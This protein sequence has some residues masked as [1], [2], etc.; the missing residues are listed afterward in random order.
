MADRPCQRGWRSYRW[1]SSIVD[2][3]K[4]VQGIGAVSDPACIRV[5]RS[6]G[7]GPR[8]ADAPHGRGSWQSRKG[9]VVTRWVGIDLRWLFRR[10]LERNRSFGFGIN[11]R[12]FDDAAERVETGGRVQR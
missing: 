2:R 12:R 9:D 3:G 7:P 4:T 11:T 1:V 8:V 10:R 5:A 6:S